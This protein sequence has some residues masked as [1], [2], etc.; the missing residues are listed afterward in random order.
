[1]EEMTAGERDSLTSWVTWKRRSD[2]GPL[3]KVVQRAPGVITSLGY[4][5]CQNEIFGAVAAL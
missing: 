4:R 2:L 3:C 1:M 5:S